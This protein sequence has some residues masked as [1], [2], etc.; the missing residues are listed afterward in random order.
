M[1]E[2]RNNNDLKDNYAIPRDFSLVKLEE[3]KNIKN[4]FDNFTSIFNEQELKEF[5]NIVLENIKNNFKIIIDNFVP[6]FGKDFFDR[7]TKHNELQK[8][9]TLYNNLKYSIIQSVIYYITLC[10]Y[11]LKSETPIQLPQDIKLKIFTLNNLEET[12]KTKNI[13][14][15]SKL[16]SKLDQFFEDTKNFIVEKYINEMK[17]DPNIDLNFEQNIKTIIGQT[18]DGRRNIFE[19]EYINLMNSIIK[20][21][22]IEQYTNTINKEANNLNYEVEKIKEG[23]REELNKIFTLNADTVLTDI[24]TKLNE[25]LKA[26]KL[27]NNQFDTFKISDEIQIYLD[28]FGKDIIYPYFENIKNILDDVT[29]ELIMSNLEKNSEEFEKEYSLEIFENKANEINLN[30]TSHFNEMNTSLKNYASTEEEYESNLKKER[31]NYQ[32]IRILEETDDEKIKYRQQAA[33]YKLDQT[34]QELKNSSKSIKEFIESLNLFTNFEEKVNKYINTINY[35]NG[36]SEKVIKKNTEYY[37]VLSTKLYELNSLSLKY[38]DKVNS[39]YNK[40]KEFIINKIQSIYESIEKS[41]N[42]TYE[43]I[44]NQYIVIKN[45]FS[46]TNKKI[47]DKKESISVDDYIKEEEVGNYTIKTTIEN[48]KIDNEFALDIIFEK[49]ENVKK[50]KVLGKVI[51]KNQPKKLEINFS[52]K[53]GQ[54]CGKIRKKIISEFYN[55]SLSNDII[56]D[57]G[58]NNA[59]I[60]TNFGYDEYEVNIEF[61]EDREITEIIDLGGIIFVLPTTCQSVKVQKP[62]NETDFEEIQSKMINYIK[63][64]DY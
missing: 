29:K 46:P 3:F 8:I 11:Q 59:K 42:I 2:M 10:K 24:E 30:L 45:D 41:N 36:V 31:A 17:N 37:E 34:L 5:K 61:Y 6:S 28:N 7:I 9:K 38:Y 56:F 26:V 49:E 53:T 15:I 16:N 43:V 50:P 18:L 44:A 55:I 40:L 33:D 25:T 20:G 47:D 27:Y 39:T 13:Q 22:F 62:E 64:Y 19:N 4:S 35:Q 60:N 48:Y 54:T 1:E 23:G 32:R 51:N 12:V 63:T 57:A 58:L 52:S 21:P 14:V